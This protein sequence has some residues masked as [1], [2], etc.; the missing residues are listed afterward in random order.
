MA[1]RIELERKQDRAA[2]EQGNR[3]NRKPGCQIRTRSGI[4]LQPEITPTANLQR[5]KEWP[6]QKER[7]N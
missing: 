3:R 5:A 4:F 7:G 6:E 2:A 1:Q